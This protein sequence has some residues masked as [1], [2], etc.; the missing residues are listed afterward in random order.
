MRLFYIAIEKLDAN[1]G[2][3]A[4]IK[5]QVEVLNQLGYDTT[6]IFIEYNGTLDQSYKLEKFHKYWRL[7]VKTST[8]PLISKFINRKRVFGILHN[9]LKK[10]PFDYVYMR[11][12]LYLDIPLIRFL[13]HFRDRVVFENQSLH[14][15]EMLSRRH[16]GKYLL[17]SV[18]AGQVYAKLKA[19]VAVTPDIADFYRR[20]TNRKNLPVLSLSNGIGV[21]D[22]PVKQ[23]KPI[24]DKKFSIIM[25]ASFFPHHGVDRLLKGLRAYKGEYEITVHLVGNSGIDKKN[26]HLQNSLGK[27]VIEYGAMSGKHL[28]K[29]YNQSHLAIGSLGIHRIKGLKE[30][31]PLKTRE[32]IARGIPFAI[33]Y[34]DVDL[35][36]GNE[37]ED[38]Y[39]QLPQ[40]DEPVDFNGLISSTISI[41]KKSD[42]SVR[43]RQFAEN[44][45]DWNIKMKKLGSF[46]ESL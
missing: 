4:K 39:I 45:F 43:L 13:G 36:D 1:I 37:I 9:L 8:C 46:L 10:E 5:T 23:H 26:N 32:Y 20:K 38:C 16:L 33:G 6:A 44:N 12:P 34:K 31:T 21:H 42:V 41:Y 28:D 14:T 24:E 17:D 3:T 35:Y 27:N 30:A 7:V 22:I 15:G 18:L 11:F 29:V 25:V 19:I 40:N 2:V